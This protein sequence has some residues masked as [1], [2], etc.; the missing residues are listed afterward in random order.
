MI[1]HP[2]Q[3]NPG[4]VQSPQTMAPPVL[5]LKPTDFSISHSLDELFPEVGQLRKLQDAERRLD[6]FTTRK[7]ADLQESAQT[8]IKESGIL[9]IFIYNTCE[10]QLWQKE[11]LKSQGKEV[12]END[13]ATWTL[14]VEGRLLNDKDPV[15]SPS[16][17][18]F[19][20]YLTGLAIDLD[21][22]SKFESITPSTLNQS[23]IEWHETPQH[24]GNRIS[25]DGMDVKR[26]GSD[27]VKCKITI[28]PKEYPTKFKLDSKLAELLGSYEMSETDVIF[29]LWQY[30]Q[31][32]KLHDKTDK[33]L[34]NC[35][36]DLEELFKVKQIAFSDLIHVIR[37]FLKPVEP[38]VLDYEVATDKSST[39]GEVVLDVNVEI[40]N[41]VLDEVNAKQYTAME[42]EMIT[43]NDPLIK[44][45]D[46]KIALDI[47]ALNSSR[48]KYEFF[49]KFA[50]DPL[51]FLEKW[52]ESH[53]KSLKILLGD[54]GY[55]EEN[56][57]RSEFYTDELL[58][59]NIDLLLNSNRL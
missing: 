48:T 22:N 21:T 49:K 50:E 31:I 39:L 12:N 59:E 24:Q 23:V 16:R 3:T 54:E 34:V 29:S 27:K 45:L 46:T 33:R 38:I 10:N 40:R 20:N 11:L 53:A 1:K 14:R 17:L 52:Q 2:I 8:G 42:K 37:N 58:D 4:A 28:Q 44:E 13:P 18:K 43:K 26:K 15:D 25:F 57:R 5:S 36:Q 6:I 51:N 47:Q 7:W 35:D 30:I 56:A 32:N 9:R 41:P 19:S 55:T